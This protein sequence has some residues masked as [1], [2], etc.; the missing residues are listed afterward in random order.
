MK[1]QVFRPNFPRRDRDEVREAGA[2]FHQRVTVVEGRNAPTNVK[3]VNSPSLKLENKIK[4]NLITGELL[5]PDQAIN[6]HPLQAPPTEAF[7]VA[8]PQRP[9]DSEG[10]VCDEIT[11]AVNAGLSSRGVRGGKRG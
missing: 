8:A 3:P 9:A 11:E 1:S 7:P 10:V 5:D 6:P 2:N 4:H